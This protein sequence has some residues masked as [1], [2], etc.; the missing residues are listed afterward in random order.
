MTLSNSNL[1][2]SYVRSVADKNQLPLRIAT[3]ILI[4]AAAALL[5][6]HAGAWVGA[7]SADFDLLPY[8][9]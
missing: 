1:S 7:S 6:I 4:T 3:A 5:L 8:L 2:Q 9:Y